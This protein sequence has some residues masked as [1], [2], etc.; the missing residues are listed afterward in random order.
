MFSKYAIGF[1]KIFHNF[2][3]LFLYKSSAH[4]TQGTHGLCLHKILW[5]LCIMEGAPINEQNSCAAAVRTL[6]RFCECQMGALN[7]CIP[8]RSRQFLGFWTGYEFAGSF[9]HPIYN[10]RNDFRN[11]SKA[12]SSI[13]IVFSFIL[14]LR[15]S[16]T[17]TTR[18]Y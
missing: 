10:R 13:Y 16:S 17:G 14:V 9:L 18:K 5:H 2:M 1:L 3:Y 12:V 8:T 6:V 4:N 11:I 7:F 15:P